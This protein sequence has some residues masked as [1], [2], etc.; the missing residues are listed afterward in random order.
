MLFLAFF[1]C[2]LNINIVWYL[3]IVCVIQCITF[4]FLGGLF[5]ILNDKSVD[6][7]TETLAQGLVVNATSLEVIGRFHPRDIEFSRP[8]DMAVSPDGAS[9]YVVE[10]IRSHVRKFELGKYKLTVTIIFHTIT[11]LLLNTSGM[12][13]YVLMFQTQMFKTNLLIK[14]SVHLIIQKKNYC[15][16][17]IT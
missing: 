6:I 16:T 8:H 11:S 9:V 12:L 15:C 10:L 7:V 14:A 3:C 1:L 2:I 5:Y 13:Q 4:L 17:S